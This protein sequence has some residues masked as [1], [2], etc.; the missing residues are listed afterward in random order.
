MHVK[1][2]CNANIL[3]S[4]IFGLES[5]Y[6]FLWVSDNS[7]AIIQDSMEGLAGYK[8]WLIYYAHHHIHR[9]W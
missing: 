5:R 9:V 7:M 3:G 1:F 4:K 6:S 2:N 8:T